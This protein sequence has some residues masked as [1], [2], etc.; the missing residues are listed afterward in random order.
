MRQK[1][2][3]GKT[4][5]RIEVTKE[6]ERKGGRGHWYGSWGQAANSLKPGQGNEPGRQKKNTLYS[7]IPSE[8]RLNPREAG[9]SGARAGL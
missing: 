1:E 9:A 3:N 6:K 8:R 5:K 2:R 4:D 7:A